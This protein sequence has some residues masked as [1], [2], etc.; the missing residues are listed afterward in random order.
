MPSDIDLAL[1]KTIPPAKKQTTKSSEAL[2]EEYKRKIRNEIESELFSLK[3]RAIEK[4]EEALDMA[5]TADECLKV[6]E[7]LLSYL[8]VTAKNDNVRENNFSISADVLRDIV[9][10]IAKVAE[11]SSGSGNTKDQTIVNQDIIETRI[12]N[13]ES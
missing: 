13:E 1:Q 6:G 4:I 5:E 12:I 8:G 7:K 3:D 9:Q 11:F 10:G 2:S